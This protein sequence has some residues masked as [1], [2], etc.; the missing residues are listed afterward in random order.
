MELHDSSL[1]RLTGISG[2]GNT[3]TVQIGRPDSTAN[4]SIIRLSTYSNQNAIYVS[5]SGKVG[6]GTDSPT[7]DYTFGGN[8]KTTAYISASGTIHGSNL[9]GT[10][11]GDQDLSSYAQT[12]NVV[13]NSSTSSFALASNVVA[14]SS[15]SS[16]VEMNGTA[17]LTTITADELS[18][19][20]TGSFIS[21]AGTGSFG[22]LKVLGASINL[23]NLP[24]E[25]PENINAQG[26]LYTQTG[27]QCGL[28][29][30]MAT[31]K[32]VFVK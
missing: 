20:G 13:A 26:H 29:G 25:R 16:F 11:T 1:I 30:S 15:T 18:S 7:H 31:H 19:A 9:S 32:V 17:S 4:K 6:F 14:N 3:H 10:N 24:T 12:V 2:V 5:D 8:I 28:T 22:S 21:S 27:A 23:S